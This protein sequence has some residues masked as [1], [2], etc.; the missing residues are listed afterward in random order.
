VNENARVDD[1]DSTVVPFRRRSVEPEPEEPDTAS[2]GAERVG[3]PRVDA[4]L[5]FLRRRLTGDVSIDEFG[6]D[7]ELSDTV[8]LRPFRFLYEN[9]FRIQV[10]GL[11]HVPD[12]G[13]AMIVG[14]HA[15][16]IAIDSMM[17]SI[18]LL[19]HHPEH[20][21]LR[22]L[23][24]DLVFGMP[25]V[26]EY[27]RATGSTLACRADVDRLLARDE[28]VGVWP[29]GYKGVGK[30]YAD[31]YRLQRFGRGGF[32]AAALRAKAPIIPCAIVGAEEIAPILGD[33]TPVARLLGLP[34]VP[35][36]PTFPWFG[37]L[38]LIP[39]PSRWIIEF[40]EP[41]PTNGYEDGASEDPAL[42]LDL[43]DRV[44]ETIQSA[45]PRLLQQR[46]RAFG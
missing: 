10:Q 32:V 33:M 8:L 1:E 28:L 29:E 23:G 2:E 20:R 34:Y 42:L 18:A 5:G 21:R 15:G 11:E 43:T 25:F 41:I 12:T 36:T 40:G 7:A 4:V 22:V 26:G 39:L 14:N 9:W 17:T 31:R 46:G 37:P 13:A 19:D 3:D 35:I 44:R 16:T 27:A 6:L 45:L 24:G 38:G 30:R